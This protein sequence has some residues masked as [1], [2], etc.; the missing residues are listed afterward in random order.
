M[1]V[2][3]SLPQDIDSIA[4]NIIPDDLEKLCGTELSGD[5]IRDV[6]TRIMSGESYTAASESG[7]IGF[8]YGLMDT[9]KTCALPQGKTIMYVP[10]WIIETSAATAL[11]SIEEEFFEELGNSIDKL[12]KKTMGL[13]IAFTA[14]PQKAN[15]VRHLKELGFTYTKQIRENEHDFELYVRTPENTDKSTAF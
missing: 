1:I 7:V 2:R 13:P 12:Y 10:F 8:A 3:N 4:K 6:I 15:R 5:R 14:N 11:P 9:L